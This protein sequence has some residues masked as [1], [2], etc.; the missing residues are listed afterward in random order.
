MRPYQGGDLSSLFPKEKMN[1]L[2]SSLKCFSSDPKTQKVLACSTRTFL[3]SCLKC[4]SS[5][6]KTQKVLACSTRTFL[7]SCLKCFS[8]DPKTQKVFACSTRTFLP[9]YV[10]PQTLKPKKFLLAPQEPFFPAP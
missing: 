9:S 7:P 5:D 4:F 6:P 10:F 1:F 2:P 3:P 8:S